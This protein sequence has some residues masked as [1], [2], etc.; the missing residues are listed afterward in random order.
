MCKQFWLVFLHQKN[1]TKQLIL[2]QK[3]KLI[4]EYENCWFYLKKQ[5]MLDLLQL[6]MPI[7]SLI[8]IQMMRCSSMICSLGISSMRW[9]RLPI[10][11]EQE[12]FLERM[13]L[14]D[15]CW[16]RMM[17][18]SRHCLKSIQKSI[19]WHLSRHLYRKQ[20]PLSSSAMQFVISEGM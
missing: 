7:F 13:L 20:L 15:T 9:K 14:M 1:K 5:T 12:A 8:L 11:L 17:I 6:L 16:S 3:E 19:R 10:T 4:K 2:S 18:V